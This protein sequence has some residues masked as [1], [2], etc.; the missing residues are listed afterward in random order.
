MAPYAVEALGNER[1]TAKQGIPG[2]QNGD[3]EVVKRTW[4]VRTGGWGVCLECTDVAL[5]QRAAAFAIR[6]ANDP[7]FGYDQDDRW[8][9]DSAIKAAG[10]NIEAAAASEVDCSSLIDICYRLAGLPV[11]K[12]YTGNLE[13]RYLATGKFIAH[14]EPKYL[15]SADY[16]RTGWLY[17]TAGKHVAILVSDGKYSGAG[18]VAPTPAVDEVK[19]PYVQITGKV[20]VRRL[21]GKKLDASGKPLYNDKGT[22]LYNGASIYV[23]KDTRLPFKQTDAA[24][25]WYMVTCPKGTG[26]VSC[27]VPDHAKLISK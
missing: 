8:T 5:A 3:T 4:R 26:Y 7:S 12:G 18:E 22:A 10:G 20:N 6:I 25:G 11:E 24:T 1:G 14:R 21:P 23:A 17:L 2:E 13:R 27:D 15:Q 16:A 9:A 19:P